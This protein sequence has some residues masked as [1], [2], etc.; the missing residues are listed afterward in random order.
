ME[1][2]LINGR[3]EILA[4]FKEKYGITDWQTVRRWRK[5]FTFPIRYYP[6]GKPYL[7]PSEAIQWAINYDNLRTAKNN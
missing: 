1:F 2:N 3:K 4:F 5:R 6:N 7:I